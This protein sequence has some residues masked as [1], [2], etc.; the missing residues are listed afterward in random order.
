M[1]IVGSRSPPCQILSTYFIFSP[2]SPM[3]SSARLYSFS[4]VSLQTNT[5]P[6]YWWSSSSSPPSFW[7]S[8][9]LSSP[10]VVLV[11]CIFPGVVVLFPPSLR[12]RLSG[13]SFLFFSPSTEVVLINVPIALQEFVRR[14][15]ALVDDS[16]LPEDELTRLVGQRHSEVF[17]PWPR[18]RSGLEFLVH[19]TRHCLAGEQSPSSFLLLVSCFRSYG[20]NS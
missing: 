8:S 16:E 2:L 14:Q 19:L 11:V 3:L 13:T 20:Q 4:R 17:P 12:S 18:R 9:C 15:L 7:Y 6:S 5:P 10:H 1:A